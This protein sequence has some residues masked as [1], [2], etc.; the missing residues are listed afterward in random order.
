MTKEEQRVQRLH[1]AQLR[2][3]GTGLA[4]AMD[5]VNM[6]QDLSRHLKKDFDDQM[7]AGDNPFS[8]IELACRALH[9]ELS[10][11]E[12]VTIKGE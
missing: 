5:H 9:D 8:V 1:T 4:Q 12:D 6:L 11:L 2:K 10:L 3:L 7:C